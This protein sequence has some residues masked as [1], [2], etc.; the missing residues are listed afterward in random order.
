MGFRNHQKKY[1]FMLLLF[2]A[3][4]FLLFLPGCS[5]TDQGAVPKKSEAPAPAKV[6]APVK[7]PEPA[8]AV[9]PPKAQ[10]PVKAKEPAK[11][12]GSAVKPPKKEAPKTDGPQQH[13]TDY[14]P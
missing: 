11:A 8:K 7:P 5:K 4:V 6:E 2:T 12:Q 9:E 14:D 3:F 13:N 1:W 10:E